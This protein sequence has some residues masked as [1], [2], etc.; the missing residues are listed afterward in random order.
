MFSR[1]VQNTWWLNA[2]GYFKVEVSKIQFCIT[3]L[4]FKV[5]AIEVLQNIG[6]IVLYQIFYPKIGMYL[7]QKIF[8]NVMSASTT[9]FVT[10]VILFIWILMLFLTALRRYC[11][12]VHLMLY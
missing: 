10:S 12:F 11:I 3:A 9:Q 7:E 1:D 4:I 8:T 2:I 5:Y 6:I